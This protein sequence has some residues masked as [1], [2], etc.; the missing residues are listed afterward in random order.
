MRYALITCSSYE[1]KLSVMAVRLEM[2]D[3]QE[4]TRPTTCV[5]VM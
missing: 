4:D 3:I 2:D 5:A 1:S